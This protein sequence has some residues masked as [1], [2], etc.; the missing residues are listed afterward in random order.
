MKLKTILFLFICTMWL[1]ACNSNEEKSKTI[2]IQELINF[3]EEKPDTLQLIS[4]AKDIKII[5]KT[6]KKAREFGEV[7]NNVVPQ[8]KIKLNDD[9]YYLW[10]DN[11]FTGTIANVN[12]R[13]MFYNI[14]TTEEFKEAIN[15]QE[16]K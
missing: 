9:E 12:S 8:Y 14:Y 7:D 6:F 15:Y 3:E 16:Q 10:I 4:D 1:V 2:E 5:E 13:N 11:T